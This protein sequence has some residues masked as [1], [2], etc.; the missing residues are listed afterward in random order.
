MDRRSALTHGIV[1]AALAGGG[2]SRIASAAALIPAAPIATDVATDVAAALRGPALLEAFV[3]MRARTDGRTA[4]GWL[5]S[6]RSAVVG[7][8]VAPLCGVVAGAVQRFERIADDVFEATILEVAHY[9]DPITGEL[10]E[11]VTMPGTG[12]MVRVPSYRFG[13]VKARFAVELDE[14][15][16]FDP[17]QGG[18]G[19]TQFVP[20]SS[21]RLQRSLGPVEAVGERVLLQANEYGRVY[22]DRTKPNTI[23]YRE[24]MSWQARASDLAQ[25]GTPS[26]PA[27][28][29]YTA[30][31]SWRPWMQMGDIKGH[32][33]DSG[34]GTNASS[35]S[36]CPADFLAM[37][38][39]LHP[40]V[41]DDPERAL[42]SPP[43]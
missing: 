43:A 31:T 29:S 8:E 17:P 24:W 7:G 6:Q 30:L 16:E 13:P 20:K 14:W 3:R 25:R 23:Y 38:R 4:F 37:T 33:I 40:D 36:E 18:T 2:A 34:H 10:L 27:E 9:T 42:R 15:E 39:R 1:A 12:R 28:Y 41:L 5:R 32:T 35:W 19:A 22:P 11:T 21:V 26:V